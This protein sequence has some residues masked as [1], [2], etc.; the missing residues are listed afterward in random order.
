MPTTTNFGWTTPA[1]TDLVKDGAAAI[2]TFAGNV[3]T[4]LVDLKGGTS[5]QY[6]T[7]NSNTDLDYAWV[8]LSAGGMT[9]ISTTTLTG[10]SITLSTIPSGYN[11]LELR[12]LNFLPAT[13]GAECRMRINADSNTRYSWGVGADA[14]NET[15]V[16]LNYIKIS[17]PNDNSVAR[18][19]NI[20][21]IPD[22]TSTDRFKTGQTVGV[23]VNQTTTANFNCNFTR[24]Y[25]NQLAA[26][27]SLD[28][29]PSSGNFTSGT[30]LLYG[31]K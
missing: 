3:D 4:S 23:N 13:D 15:F 19:L 8:T 6:L 20:T 21:T 1:D 2:R 25:Y 18:G 17:A 22:Y 28:I 27:T 11:S 16:S 26:I 29:F 9:L 14:D 31:V 5:G 12:I 24:F 30:A 7:K 10:S